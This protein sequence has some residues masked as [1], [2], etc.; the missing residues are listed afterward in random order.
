M[1]AQVFTGVRQDSGDPEDFIKVMREF[2]DQVGI[3]EKKGVV[4]SDSLNVDKCLKYKKIAE[5]LNFQPSFGI[6]TFLTSTPIF[7][8]L[9]N[10][11]T[12]AP[13]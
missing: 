10:L 11:V 7:A 6:G 4:F 2:Y 5:A 12:D 3:E 1:Y 8:L 9:K 13:I